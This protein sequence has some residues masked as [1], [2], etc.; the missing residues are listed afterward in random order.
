MFMNSKRG[1]NLCIFLICIHIPSPAATARNAPSPIWPGQPQGRASGFSESQ[2]TVPELWLPELLPISGALPILRKKHFGV[3]LLYGI[4]L[5]I[6]DRKG[7]VDLD[8]ELLCKLDYAIASMHTWNYRPGTRDE[9]T[10]AFVN[11]MKNP[12]V[13]VLG[14]SDNTHY[15]VNYDVLARTA[16]ETGT[17]FEI[18]E[19]SLAP[20]GYRGDTRENCYEILR[21]CRKYHLPL[22]LSSDSHGPE[23][24]GDFT[25]AAE[26]VHQAMF[27]EQLI[28]NNQL[29]RLKV[30]L[31]TR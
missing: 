22:L 6:L 19:A 18:N 27:P 5:N 30:F 29:P 21:C 23:H 12:C 17:I 4:E 2:T 14:H 16:R 26:F 15:P 1:V 28:L 13:K 8:Q 3:D 20:Y 7:T 25:C 24:I 31:Q 9:N 10:E 11:V